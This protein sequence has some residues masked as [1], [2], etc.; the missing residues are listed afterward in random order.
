M[1][2]TV[3]DVLVVSLP[4]A[5]VVFI[6]WVDESLVSDKEVA[7]G[8]SLGTDVANEGFLFGMGTD[9][10]LEV[11]LQVVL[12]M[13]QRNAIAEAIALL[14]RTS[15]A[16]R[17]WQCGQGNVLLLLPDCFLLTRPEGVVAVCA[18]MIVLRRRL[19][20]GQRKECGV[21]GRKAVR[22]RGKKSLVEQEIMRPLLAQNR[23]SITL[24]KIIAPG[25][26]G[27][28]SP[29]TLGA[30]PAFLFLEHLL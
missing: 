4:T 21:R 20:L 13:L 30:L 6:A 28:D 9:M 17:R 1:R 15:L 22:E 19:V 7:A 16:K 26:H 14:V 29:S 2:L 23:H 18:S 8:K 3:G 24:R 5:V 10:S 11:L 25:C 27:F 12:A